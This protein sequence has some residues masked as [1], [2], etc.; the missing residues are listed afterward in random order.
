MLENPIPLPVKP[1]S[2]YFAV[3][4]GEYERFPEVAKQ[5]LKAAE[6][7]GCLFGKLEVLGTFN[8]GRFQY[9][10]MEADAENLASAFRRLE[11]EG[12][13]I[14][15]SMGTSYVVTLPDGRSGTVPGATMLTASGPKHTYK[16]TKI[17]RWPRQFY[18]SSRE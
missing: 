11:E 8:M 10:R 18:K 9:L 3:D 13:S 2:T 14:V 4:I 6:K 12:R 15:R 17:K 1:F 5:V 7:E 16:G